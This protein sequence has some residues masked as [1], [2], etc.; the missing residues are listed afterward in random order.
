M[1]ISLRVREYITSVWVLVFSVV[2]VAV[3][4]QHNLQVYDGVYY[5]IA[6]IAVMVLVNELLNLMPVDKAGELAVV[7][8]VPAAFLLSSL[9]NN[10]ANIRYTPGSV[11]F[12]FWGV[13]IS[14]LVISNYILRKS[15]SITLSVLLE[16]ISQNKWFLLVLFLAVLSRIPYMDT[17]QRWDAGEYYARFI[18]EI[19]FFSYQSFVDYLNHFTLCGH[20]TLAFCMVYMIGEL[21][22]PKQI[23]GVM[24]VNQVLTAAA[25]WCIY[26]ILRKICIHA[27]PLRAAL[28]TFAISF[29]PLFFGTFGYFNPDYALAMFFVYMLYGYVYDK[30]IVAGWGAL[31]C[32]QTK[33]TGLV[34]V[35][36]LVLGI[37]AEH[38][39]RD[40]LKAFLAIVTDLRLYYMLIAVISYWFY[41]KW[42][43]G[44]TKWTQTGEEQSAVFWDN[45]G[46]NCFGINES[47]ILVK[48]KQQFILNFNWVL[49]GLIGIGL[50][51]LLIKAVCH[52]ID[53]LKK[54]RLPARNTADP[55]KYCGIF[56]AFAAFVVFSCLYI[57]A[58]M[59]RYN[60]V[61][62]ILLYMMAFGMLDMMVCN[63][64]ALPASFA[65]TVMMFAECFYTVDPVTLSE[66]VQIDNIIT[67]M[68]YV[69]NPARER[70]YGDYLIYNTQYTYIDRSM[71]LMLD[72]VDYTGDMGIILFQD[73]GGVQ[74]MGNTPLYAY[75]WDKLRRR[76]CFYDSADTDVMHYLEGDI[77]ADNMDLKQKAIFV[78]L[79][80]YQLDEEK[81]LR[82]LRIFYY[83]GPAQWVYTDQGAI[84]YYEMTL[85]EEF[86]LF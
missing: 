23:I 20:P 53:R 55:L 45:N 54:H 32:I 74:I 8:L 72:A 6:G 73:Y 10:A 57:T 40:R 51:V 75:R 50:I 11:Q 13:D 76:R 59:A 41:T 30:P 58:A 71:D 64:A 39:I 65:L 17:L 2:Y 7:C 28:Y 63:R 3:C 82:R 83:V 56:G 81:A 77:L 22:F 86:K 25:L 61:G 24:L 52:I 18:R 21:M 16:N 78:R 60:V 66:F 33:E 38:L 34:L 31:L 46:Y 14:L 70:Y 4:M 68:V 42:I 1:S 9:F 27:T 37:F 79:P 47:H 43:G 48:L 62:D 29:A 36:G 5:C 80:Y 67:P 12:F 84:K 15:D 26:R 35:A 19:E 49:V 69:G 44:L 85:L